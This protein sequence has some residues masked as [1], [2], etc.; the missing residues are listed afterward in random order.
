MRREQLAD[1]IATHEAGHAIAALALGLT[2]ELV[3]CRLC[4]PA[5][6]TR[7]GAQEAGERVQV[8]TAGG[9]PVY[10]DLPANPAASGI[11]ELAGTVAV[12]RAKLAE[13]TGQVTDNQRAMQRAPAIAGLPG[14]TRRAEQVFADWWAEAHRLLLQHEAA[15]RQL[16]AALVA[17]MLEHGE[18]SLTPTLPA[19]DPQ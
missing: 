17:G 12:A 9:V 15:H 5:G 11:V 7:V 8:A 19:P 16:T 4:P 13:P 6:Q 1:V 3:S 2:V 18:A 10:A 14:E